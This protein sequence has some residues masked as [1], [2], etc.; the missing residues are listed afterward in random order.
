[1]CNDQSKLV[2][3]D[4]NQAA[5]DAAYDQTVYAP[6]YRQ[7]ISRMT[8]ASDEVI[9]RLPAARTYSFGETEIE[10]LYY[11]APAYADAPVHVHIHGGAWRQRS[12]RAVA[13]PAQMFIAAGIGF[14]VFDFISVDET[15]GDLSPML[16]Q[17]LKALAW[18]ARNAARIGADPERL[19]LSGFS[20]GAHLASTALIS[21][22]RP[23][24][25]DSNPY[26]SAVL[27]SGMFDLYPVSLSRR[28]EYVRFSDE[29]IRSMSAMQHVDRIDLPVVLAVGTAETP[30]FKRQTSAFH[31]ALQ[32]AGK[33]AE[34]VVCENFNHFE[35]MELLGNPY[36]HI[37][38]SALSQILGH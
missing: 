3:L 9:R 34:L 13:F 14:A 8:H 35:V 16:H 32:D 25:F 33:P 12:A 15:G 27:L 6:N 17:V 4:M 5:L 26:G 23:Y 20:S 19:Q 10:K 1:M 38:R 24:G 11:F 36:S 7:V 30:E 37:S 31:A 18:V 2:W 28:S 22:W 21:D 29:I